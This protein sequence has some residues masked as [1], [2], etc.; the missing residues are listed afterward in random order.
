MHEYSKLVKVVAPA[1]IGT[2]D[3]LTVALD[4]DLGLSAGVIASIKPFISAK[5]STAGVGKTIDDTV[6]VSGTDLVIT[7]GTTGF[8]AGDVFL[9]ELVFGSVNAVTAVGSTA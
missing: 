2:G 4:D 6:A 5:T 7:E 1:D 8:T 3:T 9:V